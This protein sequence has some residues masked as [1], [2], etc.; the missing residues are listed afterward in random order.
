MCK[1]TD[2]TDKIFTAWKDE[3]QKELAR[4]RKEVPKGYTICIVEPGNVHPTLALVSNDEIETS[5]EGLHNNNGV[6]TRK[7]TLVTYHEEG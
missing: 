4:L 2:L 5:M 3:D 7:R 1:D 6:E